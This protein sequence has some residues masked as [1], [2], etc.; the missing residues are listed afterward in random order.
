MW[1]EV[2]DSGQ[3]RIYSFVV[4]R[5]KPDD[6]G[7]GPKYK[8][9]IVADGNKQIPIEDYDPDGISFSV[10]KTTTLKFLFCKA[11]EMGYQVF[12][13]DVVTAFLN[14]PVKYEI[15]M[16][17]PTELSQFGTPKLV[18]LLKGLYVLNSE[19]SQ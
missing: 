11:I 8:A 9:R 12:H 2:F 14:S 17:L 1:E 13:I 19:V 7:T 6:D 18:R 16:A 5:I 3:R 10:L 15:F 4:L